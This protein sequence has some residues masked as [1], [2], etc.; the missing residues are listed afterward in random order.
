MEKK[1][2]SKLHLT[3][4]M[5][6]YE[7]Y[8]SPMKGNKTTLLE[9]GIADGY[10]LLHWREYLPQ[11]RIIGVD[12]SA[13]KL[14]DPTGRIKTYQGEQQDCEFLDRMAAE[15]APD[16]FDVIIDDAS[17]VGQLTR[18]AFWH[19]FKNHLKPGGLYFIEDWGCGYFKTW[20]DGKQFTPRPVGLSWHE[21]LLNA[22][23]SQTFV[24][25]SRLLRKAVGYLRWH[26]VKR[27]F[28]GH[29]RGTVGFVKELVDECGAA[30][31]TDPRF[32]AKGPTRR[33]AI[34]WMRIS[35]GLVVVKKPNLS[36]AS[37]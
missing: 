31:I 11:A 36:V 22:V 9:L 23:K 17:H 27:T 16:G 24:Q 29:Q 12:I 1:C 14:D 15:A 18:I 5:Q 2:P 13:V 34:Q 30:D 10:S 32:G 19:L 25:K 7:E 28:P 4:Y 3:H 37:T 20:V 26:G 33:S 8:L 6:V 35:A 21:N